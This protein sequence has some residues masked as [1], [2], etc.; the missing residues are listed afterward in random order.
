MHDSWVVLNRTRVQRL[1]YQIE[2]YEMSDSLRSLPY[3]TIRSIISEAYKEINK[4]EGL[5]KL[6]QEKTERLEKE[7]KQLQIED[8]ES[9]IVGEIPLVI[10]QPKKGGK[11]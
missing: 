9:E 11:R 5:L 8:Q 7:I 6:E 4:L 2:Q 10:S 1:L 3:A